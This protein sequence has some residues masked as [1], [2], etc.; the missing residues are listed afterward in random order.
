MRSEQEILESHLSSRHRV[1]CIAPWNH[2]RKDPSATAAAAILSRRPRGQRLQRIGPRKAAEKSTADQSYPL[3]NIRQR[4]GPKLTILDVQ[5]KDEMDG[6]LPVKD[7]I[8]NR[9]LNTLRK[10]A[11]G[12]GDPDAYRRSMRAFARQQ[13]VRLAM[14]RIQYDDALDMGIRNG[15]VDRVIERDALGFIVGAR[16]GGNKT[17]FITPA[18]MAIIRERI[19]Q[20]ASEYSRVLDQGGKA[21]LFFE[22]TTPRAFIEWVHEAFETRGLD[23]SRENVAHSQY[24]LGGQTINPFRTTG[25]CLVAEKTTRMSKILQALKKAKRKIEAV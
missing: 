11:Q 20:A 5:R 8:T 15:S 6:H 3:L 19:S 4:T 13:G 23:V 2:V 25:T 18:N 17:I 12:R 22:R 1:L 10:R 14:P 9:R 16:P 21:I 7:P 24:H